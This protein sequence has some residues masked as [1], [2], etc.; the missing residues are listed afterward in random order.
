M[1]GVSAVVIVV[2]FSACGLLNGLP[3]VR[4]AVRYLSFATWLK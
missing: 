2:Q 3:G 4:V 1:A